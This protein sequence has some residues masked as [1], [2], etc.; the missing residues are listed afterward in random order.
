MRNLL[1]C[2]FVRLFRLNGLLVLGAAGASVLAAL[3]L[4]EAALGLVI[5]T[6]LFILK[7]F[8]LYEAGRALIRR[9]SKGIA[10]A[11]AA[12]S[13]L[14]RVVFLAVALVLVAQ[15]G[16]PPLLAACAGLVL[17]QLNLHL[18][19]IIRRKQAQCSST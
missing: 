19:Y 12:L 14:G 9:D 1:S 18:S 10:R 16:L 11:I 6:T 13:S 15:M 8:F 7:S 2:E 4:T 17:G 5:G 3:G